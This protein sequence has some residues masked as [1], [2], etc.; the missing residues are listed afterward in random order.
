MATKTADVKLPDGRTLLK[1]DRETA[2]KRGANDEALRASFGGRARTPKPDA[3][4]GDKKETKS[5][6]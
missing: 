4:K 1:V 3:V 6:A 5:D 2:E